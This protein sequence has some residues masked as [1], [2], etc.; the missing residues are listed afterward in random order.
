MT[1]ASA[2]KARICMVRMSWA[3]MPTHAGEPPASMNHRPEE[4]PE[5]V[6]LDMPLDFMAAHLLIEG[7]E[8]LLAGGRAGEKGALESGC[9]RRAA[10]IALALG[11]AIEGDAHAVEQIDDRGAQ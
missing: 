8:Q 2:R 9:R 10:A 3:T 11:R 7:V 5:L 4:F 6:F 1:T